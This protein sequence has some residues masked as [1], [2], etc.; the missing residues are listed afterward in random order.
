M[1]T[2]PP[3]GPVTLAGLA[4]IVRD[5]RALQRRFFKGER[6]GDLIGRA[7][8]LERRVDEAVAAALATPSMFDP[9][10]SGDAP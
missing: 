6:S 10:E 2:T 4:E 7:K 5:M 1:A 3:D 8:A 9:P